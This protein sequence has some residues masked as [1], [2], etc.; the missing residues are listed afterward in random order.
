VFGLIVGKLF[1]M[2]VGNDLAVFEG[3]APPRVRA[4]IEIGTT[5]KNSKICG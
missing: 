2:N 3:C 5:F 1:F 4:V